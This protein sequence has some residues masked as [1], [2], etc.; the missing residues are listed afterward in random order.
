MSMW[1]LLAVWGAAIS[2]VVL[3]IEVRRALRRRG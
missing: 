2:T 3:V 1:D